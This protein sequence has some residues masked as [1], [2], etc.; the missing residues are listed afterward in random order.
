MGNS[1]LYIP[2][3][4]PLFESRHSYSSPPTF[5]L[6][7]PDPF[8]IGDRILRNVFF[9]NFPN[10]PHLFGLLLITELIFS[11]LI[12][13]VALIA[14]HIHFS[15]G[16]IL[17]RLMKSYLFSWLRNPGWRR[18][19]W[20]QPSRPAAR[21]RFGAQWGAFEHRH[22]QVGRSLSLSWWIRTVIPV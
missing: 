13:S 15:S 20:P 18:S 10:F 12:I 21:G 14:R 4:S 3:L 16:V 17:Q 2:F 22:H 8:F 9:R 5:C 19:R 6:F 1:I 7:F 11:S